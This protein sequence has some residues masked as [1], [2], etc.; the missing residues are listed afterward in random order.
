[1]K[2]AFI[3]YE[4]PPET[5]Y[6][7]IGTYTYQISKALS[8]KGHYVEVFSSSPSKDTLK[9]ELE[10]N[11]ILHRVKANKRSIF[12]ERI[13]NVFQQRNAIIGFD[14]IESPEYC[15][16]GTEVRKAFP[17][18]PMVVKLHAPLFLIRELNTRYNKR[19]FKGTIKKLVG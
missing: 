2:L 12:S 3:S 15:A 9:V 5:G 18:I 10:N 1:M 17:E 8:A 4:F 13:V 16:E 7:G 11:L 19:S 14:I 6:G